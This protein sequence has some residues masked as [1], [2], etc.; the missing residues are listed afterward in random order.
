MT[1]T[2]PPPAGPP[3]AGPPQEQPG[4]PPPPLRGRLLQASQDQFVQDPQVRAG[5]VGGHRDR[6]RAV[7]Q[8]PGV[9]KRRAAGV[10]RRSDSSTSMTCPY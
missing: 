9:K 7:A 1:A 8:C 3:A 5:L 10:S 4:R 2:L 6:P